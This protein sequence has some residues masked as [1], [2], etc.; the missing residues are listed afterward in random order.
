FLVSTASRLEILSG[1]LQADL[2]DK[3]VSDLLPLLV[4]IGQRLTRPMDIP[5]RLAE[6]AKR[7]SAPGVRLQNLLLLIR[8]LPGRPETVEALRAASTDPNPEVRLRA[9]KELGAEGCGV[10]FELAES[11]A[12]DSVS[13]EAVSILDRELPFERARALLDR[14]LARRNVRT[15][16]A[17][18]E[19]LGRSGAAA[20]GVLEKVLTQ[21]KGELATA[22]ARSLGETGSPSAEP[23]LILALRRETALQIAAANA[24]GRVGSAAAVPPLR[25]AAERSWLDLELRRAT[26]RAIAEIQSR[27]PGAT[28]GQLS[29]AGAEAGQLSLAEAEAGQLSLAADPAG[30]LSLR[31][32]EEKRG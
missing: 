21:E 32:P 1:M 11:L 9:A 2:S 8:E 28:P 19:A 20:V 15:A 25:E 27:L 3:K 17:C 7:D 6:N 16:R 10:L 26:H 30:Q 13:A 31:G 29:L 18:L 5:Q 22:A 4:E 24:L 14:V 23:S 12:D